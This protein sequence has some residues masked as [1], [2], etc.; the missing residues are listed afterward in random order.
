[1][2]VLIINDESKHEFT[3]V[4]ELGLSNLMLFEIDRIIQINNNSDTFKI[5][6][7]QT[8]SELNDMIGDLDY[9]EEYI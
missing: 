9:L 4:K 5:V 8:A 6:K 2:K 3:N 7:D 1:M